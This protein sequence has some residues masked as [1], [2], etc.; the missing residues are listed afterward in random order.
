M[1]PWEASCYEESP[2]EYI[3]KQTLRTANFKTARRSVIVAEY[4]LRAVYG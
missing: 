3:L 4:R 1:L 2:I